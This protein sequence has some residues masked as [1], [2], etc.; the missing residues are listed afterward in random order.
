MQPPPSGWYLTV[1]NGFQLRDP[2]GVPVTL[3]YRKV[4]ELLQL[5]LQH[6]GRMVSR[7]A[8]AREL[9]P[10]S[11]RE[12]RQVKLRQALSKLR[13]QIGGDSLLSTR[14]ECGLAPSFQ[15]SFER[16]K[17]AADPLQADAI[18]ATPTDSLLN[19]LHWL[20]KHD[21][22]KMLALMRENLT[23]TSSLRGKDLRELL[24]DVS[25][26]GELGSW[27]AYFEGLLIMAGGSN[28]IGGRHLRRVIADAEAGNDHRLA[29]QAAVQ[30]CLSACFQN[31]AAG[32]TQAAAWCMAIASSSKSRSL[33]PTSTHL[34]GVAQVYAGELD[35]G[36]AKIR[37]AESMYTDPLEAAEMQGLQAFYLAC[38]SRDSEAADH[39]ERAYRMGRE[40][41][42]RF[43]NLV[44]SVTDGLIALHQ[45]GAEKAM[46]KLR[47]A[48]DLAETHQNAHLFLPAVETL[49]RAYEAVGETAESR[50]HMA[51][52]QR[53]RR[54]MSLF[55]TPL[56]RA[57]L[58]AVCRA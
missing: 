39:Y 54:S 55:F 24:Q 25:N 51:R 7:E 10:S 4:E 27:K 38:H 50:S 28:S 37:A 34:Q 14:S 11:E 43:L 36:L 19:L 31:D 46:L 8:L 53:V 42:H 45:H 35:K 52:A 40:S 29:A 48:V 18:S 16:P 13:E 23:M 3:A 22:P 58:S 32:A 20:A 21:Q 6:D 17:S 33:V 49:A 5:L 1:E 15:I 2:E 30:V 47:K 26:P 56:D 12:K 9:W 57:R 44:C 41:G